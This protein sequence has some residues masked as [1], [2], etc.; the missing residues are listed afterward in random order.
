MNFQKIRTNIQ[1]NTYD[2]VQLHDIT[3][4]STRKT[5][6]NYIRLHNRRNTMQHNKIVQT[7]SQHI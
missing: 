3:R 4:H 5:K 2:I 1:S 7:Q 6:Q